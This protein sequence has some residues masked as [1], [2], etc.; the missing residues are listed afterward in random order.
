VEILD[1]DFSLGQLSTFEADRKAVEMAQEVEEERF[2]TV[3]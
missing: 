3:Y 2:I 1:V